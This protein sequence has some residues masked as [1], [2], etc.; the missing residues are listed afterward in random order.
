MSISIEQG[1][2]FVNGK[3]T[4]DPVLIGYTI[5]D[6]AEKEDIIVI[7]SKNLMLN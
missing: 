6:L 5:L 7:E 2:I 3:Q 4:I 1:K